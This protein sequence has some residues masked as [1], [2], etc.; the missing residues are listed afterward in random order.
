MLPAYDIEV[1][2]EGRAKAIGKLLADS[3][4]SDIVDAFV[5]LGALARGDSII[6]S[7]P[8]DILRLAH[9][10]GSRINVLSL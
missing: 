7:D 4:T 5:L 8:D 3:R 2:D 1:L 9:A 6:T 10:L